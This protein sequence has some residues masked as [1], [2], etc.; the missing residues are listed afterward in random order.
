MK[1]TKEHHFPKNKIS[2]SPG[3]AQL[4]ADVFWT[5][6]FS[7]GNW[8]DPYNDAYKN[9]SVYCGVEQVKLWNTRTKG[10]LEIWDSKYDNNHVDPS[11]DIQKTTDSLASCNPSTQEQKWDTSGTLTS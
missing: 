2:P 3:S 1:D 7:D 9:S 8:F 10:M 11:S 6:Q 4:T 5:H